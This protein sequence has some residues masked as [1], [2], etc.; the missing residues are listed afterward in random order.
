MKPKG[1]KRLDELLV[2]LGLCESRS[3]AKAL[4]LAGKIWN[5][6]ERLDKASRLC[7]LDLEIRLESPPKY[8][9]RGG[10]KLENFLEK[11]KINPTGLKILDLGAST[12]GFTY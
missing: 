4:I 6:T 12:G 5:G 2:H 7:P 9:G 11:T 10:L 8:V 3:Q 1:K